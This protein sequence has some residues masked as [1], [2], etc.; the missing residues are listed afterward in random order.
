MPRRLIVVFAVLIMLSC[1]GGRKKQSGDLIQ[2]DICV[3]GGT[4]AGVTAAVQAARMGKRVVIVEPGFH[5]GGMT[6]GGLSWT[7][8][9]S[10]DRVASIGGLAREVYRRIGAHYGTLHSIFSDGGAGELGGGIDFDKPSELAFEPHVAEAVF[11]ELAAEAGV[12]IHFGAHVIAV[13]VKGERLQEMVTS[14]RS[15]YR[16]KIFIDATYEGDLMAAAGVSYVVGREANSTYDETLNGIQPPASN[17]RAGKYEVQ[18][19]PFVEPG[20]PASGALPYLLTG[21][22]FGSIGDA[23][24]RIQAYNYR[25]CLT[26]DTGN[27]IPLTAPEGYDAGRY[28]LLGRWIEARIAAGEELTLRDFL[29]YDPLPNNKYDF[30]NRWPISTDYIGGSHEYPEADPAKRELIAQAHE[31][32]LRGFFH[33]LRTDQRVPE[34]VRAEMARFGLPTDEFVDDGG[35]PHQIYVREARRMVSDFVMREQHCRGDE[36][37]PHP[38]ALASYGIDM[39]AVRRFVHEGQPVN[40]GTIGGA[41]PHPYPVAYDAIVPK[42]TESKNLLVPVCLSA[43][44]VA[45]GSIRMEPVF[46]A[47]GQ[48]AG[49][50]AALAV[51][52]GK[53]VQKVDYEDL[54]KRLLADGQALDWE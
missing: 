39:H 6:S 47:L 7:D 40:E 46:M 48:S 13:R 31:D 37:A 27:M 20:N 33:F 10:P 25:A 2:V 8:V 11:E 50:A 24:D 42:A 23:D 1:A 21:E 14:E 19:D 28:E 54:R 32:Y 52:S 26:D 36:V 41:V 12:D 38:V 22:P 35:W 5:L 9:G 18:V 43:S 30:N 53:D 3:Y 45:F 34:H 15:S 49:A 44:H 51:T 29:K 16:A 4:S 17:P